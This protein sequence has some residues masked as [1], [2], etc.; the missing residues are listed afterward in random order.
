LGKKLDDSD[1]EKIDLVLLD[2]KAWESNNHLR[3]TGHEITPVLEFAKRLAGIRKPAWLRFVLVPGYTDNNDEVS[4]IADF[5]SRLGN[6]ERVDV[7]PFHQ[8]GRFKWKELG[9]SYSLDKVEPPTRAEVEKIC[10]L[11]RE[12]GLKAY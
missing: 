9:M 7:L 11:F 2:I 5:V 4:K 10:A 8:M 3:M 6:I 12:K 1:L